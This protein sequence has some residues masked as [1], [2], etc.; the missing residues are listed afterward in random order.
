VPP[1]NDLDNRDPDAAEAAVD[2]ARLALRM[3]CASL[4]YLSGLAHTVR[5]LPDDRIA[6][7]AI[8][9]SGRLLVNPRWI[10]RLRL[11]E[12]TFVMAHEL[13]HLCLES[14]QRG[15]GTDGHLFN[16]AHDYIIND[17]LAA[18]LEMP[19]PAGGMA[20]EGARNLSAEQVVQMLDRSELPRPPR[21]HARRPPRASRGT[22]AEALAEA[23]LVPR[24][25]PDP[26]PEMVPENVL[27]SGD[28]LDEE[29]ER[30]MFPGV[31]PQDI[32]SAGEA[33]RAAATQAASLTLLK[34]R[35]D[36]ADAL[37]EFPGTGSGD[38][39]AVTQ[40]LRSQY[41][42]PWEL[43]LQQW[44]EAVAPGPRTYCRPS[45]REAGSPDAVLAGRS[46]VGWTLHIVLDTSGSMESEIPH[47]LGLIAGFCEAVG[48]GLVHLLQ[49]DSEVTQDDLVPPEALWSFT[50]AGFG[51][52][53][54]SPAMN[55]L[56]E[57]P[58]V[59]AVIVITDGYIR[60]PGSDDSAEQTASPLPYDVLW[61]LTDPARAAGFNP[62]YGRVVVIPPTGR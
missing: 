13:M 15:V 2:V 18:E 55:L 60:Y 51:G 24:P 44:M 56:A 27:G 6:T 47:V 48:V 34:S 10:T 58:Q 39:V 31:D 30:R 4:P 52:S 21:K 35:I 49:C 62:G 11:P 61:A 46:R 14:H 45:R 16:V 1:T 26:E 54:M 29:T 3:V 9:A 19:V 23:G 7:A 28:V 33:V 40:A 43:A 59:T 53:D 36:A 12:V 8:T 25:Q 5:I 42:P 41:V 17:I 57:D 37:S 50:V 20:H 38:A 32:R 22:L